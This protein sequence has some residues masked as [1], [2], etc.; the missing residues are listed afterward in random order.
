M[1]DK[2]AA[3]RNIRKDP[4]SDPAAS[5]DSP[6]P[7]NVGSRAAGITT[8]PPPAA[9][10]KSTAPK[11]PLSIRFPK[12]FRALTGAKILLGIGIVAGASVGVAWGAKQYMTTSPRFA[13]RAIQVDGADRKSPQEI[14]QLGGLVLGDNVF[15]VDL[16][17]TRRRIEDDP[18][19]KTAAVTRKLPG[20]IV[21]TVVEHE[22]AALVAIE[23]KLYLAAKD[24]EVFKELGPDDPLDLVVVTGIDAKEVA[25]DRE[26]VQKDVLRALEVV[27]D[28][29]K[30][31]IVKRYPVQEAHLVQD[32]TVELVVGT[33][34][35]AIHLGAPPYRGKLEQ[36]ER[37]F[38]ELARRKSDPAIVFLDNESSPDRVVVRMR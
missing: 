19:V 8:R 33:D 22:P 37:V 26:R 30:T 24:G 9:P 14:A 29:E 6:D 2:R 32:G 35:I 34:A 15:H 31:T 38:E 11:A 10:P 25:S 16:D 7:P 4:P 17:V 1:S 36:A 27:A 3:P 21:V 18:W 28:L 23:D 5:A 13:L 12:V 20:S